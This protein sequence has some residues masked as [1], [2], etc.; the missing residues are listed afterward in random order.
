[1][2]IFN[3][4]AALSS[5]DLFCSYMTF[6]HVFPVEINV[7]CHMHELIHYPKLFYYFV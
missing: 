2:C 4:F 1:M 7:P 5:I 3:S 6:F